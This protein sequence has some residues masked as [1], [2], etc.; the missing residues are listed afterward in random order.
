MLLLGYGSVGARA[1]ELGALGRSEAFDAQRRPVL[2]QRVLPPALPPALRR[3]SPRSV[4]ILPG[5]ELARL[6]RDL[7]PPKTKANDH[8]V[9]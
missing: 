2:D 5:A 4:A 3:N 8:L 9:S 7:L 6:M 1:A